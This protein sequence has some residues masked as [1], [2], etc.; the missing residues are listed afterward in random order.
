MDGELDIRGELFVFVLYEG[1]GEKA[2]REWMEVSLPFVRK[3][4]CSGS[5]AGQIP[6]VDV[7]MGAVS[8]SAVPDSDGEERVLRVEAQ[9]SLHIRLYEEETVEILEDFYSPGREIMPV[10]KEESYESLVTR[11]YSKCRTSERIRMKKG[12]QGMLQFCH[13][14]GE[15]RIDEVTMTEQGVQVEGAVQVTLLYVTADDSVPFAVLQ[16]DVPFSH[17][18]EADGVN[19]NCRCTLNTGLEQLS[20]AMIDSEEIEVKASVSLHAFVA[21]NHRYG[22]VVNIEEREPD[23]K[24]LQEMPGIVGYLVQPG[25][26]LWDIAKGFKTTPEKIKEWNQLEEGE[27]KAGTRLM[28]LKTLPKIN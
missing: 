8:L 22:F 12:A 16:G 24:K 17:L 21:E 19:K 10:K 5:S 25:D 9:L 4:E 14:Q 3:L 27:L 1:D 11:N 18:I 2:A 23:L 7:R 13:S 6:D 28:I 26:R 20:A 15:V